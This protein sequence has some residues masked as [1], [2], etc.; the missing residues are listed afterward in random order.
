[1]KGNFDEF[2]VVYQVMAHDPASAFVNQ[3]RREGLT[4]VVLGRIM[5]RLGEI[6]SE[7]PP[8]AD[9]L[10]SVR[11]ADCLELLK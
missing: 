3:L 4:Y 6:P 1:M 11:M 7:P 5:Y 8:C 10:R 2:G 9:Y